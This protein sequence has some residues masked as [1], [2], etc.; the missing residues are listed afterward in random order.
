MQ[1]SRSAPA[2]MQV[3]AIF[4]GGPNAAAANGIGFT[5]ARKWLARLGWIWGRDRKGYV[6]G[7][8][9]VDVV[10]YREKVGTLSPSPIRSTT[11]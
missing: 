3:E 5:T 1:D 10:E 2:I 8:E 4:N 7:H 11:N 9:R 6:D